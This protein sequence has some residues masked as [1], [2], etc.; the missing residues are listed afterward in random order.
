MGCELP[1]KIIL[2]S[3][4][5]GEVSRARY[6]KKTKNLIRSWGF[7]V[8]ECK[9]DLLDSDVLSDGVGVLV[10]FSPKSMIESSEISEIEAFIRSGG[11][12]LVTPDRQYRSG[13]LL[14]SFGIEFEWRLFDSKH[15]V[16]GKPT[17]WVVFDRKLAIFK[18]HP[19]TNDIKWVCFGPH[20]GCWF[21]GSSSD[22]SEVI[23]S[24]TDAQP[25]R[26]PVLVI[27]DFE[28]SGSVIA[29]G[30][31]NT[32]SSYAIDTIDMFDN[33][34]F[35]KNILVYLSDLAIRSISGKKEH[36][37]EMVRCAY[38][39]GLI[40]FNWKACPHCGKSFAEKPKCAS[41]GKKLE[42]GWK[43][44]PFCGAVVV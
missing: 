22:V 7:E 36:P 4:S 12:L 14:T 19:I 30:S 24:D 35:L 26:V 13:K 17:D 43:A 38:C 16:L 6:W 10:M 18:N 28:G 25:P 3:E 15:H 40:E 33:S 8:Q 41:C 5:H 27:R 9:K 34:A 2:F 42:Q 39:Q 1:N 21:K 44:C 20:G 11:S 23:F 31:K 32:F 37:P 29:W